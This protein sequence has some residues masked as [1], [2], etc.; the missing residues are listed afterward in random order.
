MYCVLSLR[1]TAQSKEV[2]MNGAPTAYERLR[3]VLPPFPPGRSEYPTSEELLAI[4][5][6]AVGRQ[7]GC[8]VP[9][10]WILP[11]E[12]GYRGQFNQVLK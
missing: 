5:R 2:D 8:T 1:G 11:G 4:Q 3:A 12:A 10:D 9:S 7:M 6:N